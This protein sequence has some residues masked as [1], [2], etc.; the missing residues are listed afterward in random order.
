MAK[1]S[2]SRCN[3]KKRISEFEG[4]TALA[5]LFIVG[6]V[7]TATK[8]DLTATNLCLTATKVIPTATK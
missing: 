3:I 2:S 4:G 5:V 8:L 7:A 6:I 1:R